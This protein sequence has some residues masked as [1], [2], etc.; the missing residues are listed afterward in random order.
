VIIRALRYV[1]KDL[2]VL[3]HEDMKKRFSTY[4]RRGK[5][6]DTNI[7]HRRVPNHIHF[8]KKYGVSLPLSVD[9]KDRPTWQPGDLVYWKLPSGLDHCGVVTDRM[10]ASG[11]PTV[12]HNIRITAEED[13]LNAWTITGHFRYPKA[14]SR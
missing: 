11:L 1:G 13:V 8:L 3:I 4:P 14:R 7:D 10:G 9:G 6:A 12:I 5:K 2:Q